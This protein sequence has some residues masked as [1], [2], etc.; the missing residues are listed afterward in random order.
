MKTLLFSFILILSS[1]TQAQSFGYYDKVIDVAAGELSFNLAGA[2]GRDGSTGSQGSDASC[3]TESAQQG[4]R[5]DDGENGGTGDRGG[6]AY[7]EFTSIEQLKDLYLF[8]PGGPGGSGGAGGEAGAGCNGGDWGSPGNAGYPGSPGPSGSLYLIQSPMK[9]THPKESHYSEF[10]KLAENQIVLIQN[11][12]S[13]HSGAAALIHPESI[14][15]NKYSLLQKTVTKKVLVNWQAPLSISSFPNVLTSVSL[16]NGLFNFSIGRAFMEYTI[17]E[18]DTEVTLHVTNIIA[19][20]DIAKI[21]NVKPSGSG[22]STKLKFQNAGG[23]WDGMKTSYKLT[24]YRETFFGGLSS[25]KTLDPEYFMKTENGETVI[26]IGAIPFEAKAKKK[27]SKLLFEL[28]I[29]YK[30]QGQ[31]IYKRIRRGYKV[32]KPGSDWERNT[33]DRV[34]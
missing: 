14:I 32:G 34:E 9:F 17:Q 12:W 15:Q 31:S 6:N 5:G 28:N 26:N 25:I 18:S 1:S 33:S 20:K 30:Y 8:A 24:I 7:V 10:T 16:K 19:E 13:E 3:N 2:S 21:I 22:Q 4:G 23:Q 11:I 27:G 29:E